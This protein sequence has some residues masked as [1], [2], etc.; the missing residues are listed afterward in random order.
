M[1]TCRLVSPPLNSVGLDRDLPL[2][3]RVSHVG[4]EEKVLD[5]GADGSRGFYKRLLP[6]LA[7]YLVE[8]MNPAKAWSAATSRKL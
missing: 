7:H 6:R 8:A 3:E 4:G 1:S 5:A 2:V